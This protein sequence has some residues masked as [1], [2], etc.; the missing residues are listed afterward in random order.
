MMFS[1]SER[2]RAAAA[3]AAATKKN[4]K[5]INI[6]IK[7]AG[8]QSKSEKVKLFFRIKKR[9]KKKAEI[10]GR[11]RENIERALYLFDIRINSIRYHEKE[12]TGLS[13]SLAFCVCFI[14][15]ESVS[16]DAC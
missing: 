7:S 10:N 11:T 9:R 1:R 5:E 16:D 12:H 13:L 6:W 2:F 8:F 15:C 14:L 4:R 3:T